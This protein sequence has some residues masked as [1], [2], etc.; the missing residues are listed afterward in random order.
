MKPFIPLD[1]LLFGG[2]HGTAHAAISQKTPKKAWIF[3]HHH[4]NIPPFLIGQTTLYT[5]QLGY[6]KL[7]E[8]AG[9]DRSATIEV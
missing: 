8:E 9:F 3:G 7:K 4:V 5:N 2:N 6:V 1:R